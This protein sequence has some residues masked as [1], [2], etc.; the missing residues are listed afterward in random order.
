MLLF[1]EMC[2]TSSEVKRVTDLC[3]VRYKDGDTRR[4]KTGQFKAMSSCPPIQVFQSVSVTDDG[5]H[6]GLVALFL[7]QGD[8]SI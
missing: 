6:S 8:R 2:S 5:T 4:L 3:L 7:M 1:T